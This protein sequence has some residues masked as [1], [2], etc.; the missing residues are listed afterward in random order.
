MRWPFDI[1][2]QHLIPLYASDINLSTGDTP[3]N[4]ILTNPLNFIGEAFKEIGVYQSCMATH[5]ND[6]W[7][8]TDSPTLEKLQALLKEHLE[9]N[10]K[11]YSLKTP[12]YV[13]CSE[14]LNG[15]LEIT[16]ATTYVALTTKTTLHICDTKTYSLHMGATFDAQAAKPHHDFLGNK[17]SRPPE[18]KRDEI[19]QKR[20]KP[21]HG[22]FSDRN[23]NT[24]SLK[25]IDL[26]TGCGR[27]GHTK[28]P[29][30]F[31]HSPRF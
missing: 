28:K 27:K 20:Q 11:G 14:L 9:I 18:F 22:K 17:R 23:H 5:I 31:Q 15:L 12:G 26:C 29:L 13:L 10:R 30:P 1:L 2:L 19:N 24:A 16:D 6:W 3:S 8:E 21:P 25:E 7:H 4:R